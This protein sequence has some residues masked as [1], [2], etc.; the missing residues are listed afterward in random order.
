MIGIACLS[1]ATLCYFIAAADLLL[2]E[3]NGLMAGVFACYG[4]A[5]AL[6]LLVAYRAR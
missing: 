6:L 2:R 5:N 3:R 4:V 1:V